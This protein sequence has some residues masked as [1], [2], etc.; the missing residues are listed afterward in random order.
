MARRNELDLLSFVQRNLL[1]PMYTDVDE[2]LREARQALSEYCREVDFFPLASDRHTRGRELLAVKALLRGKAYNELWATS[3]AYRRRIEE[4]FDSTAYDVVHFDTISLMQYADL[5]PEGCTT[6]LDHHNVESH[7]LW[8]RADNETH[9]LRR[10]Y[11]ALEARL[12][13]E[14]ERFWCPVVNLNIVCSDMD[15][16]RLRDVAPGSRVVTVPNGV[17]IGFFDAPAAQPRARRIV[18]VGTLDW[19]P[20]T[21]AVRMIAHDIWPRL[22]ERDPEIECDIIGGR[23][24]AD[25]V[26]LADRDD[27]FHVHGFVDDIHPWIDQALCY[28]CPIK[29]GGGTKLKILDAL[30]MSKAIVAH[31]IACEGIEVTDGLDVIFAETPDQYVDAILRLRDDEPLR[32]GLEH[33]ARRLAVERYSFH[34][35]GDHFQQTLEQTQVSARP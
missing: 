12:V 6:V 25:L 1:A 15:A 31:R 35:I 29:D 21:A 18:F 8:R 30:A 11:F 32:H 14:M 10:G 34:A 7:M 16:D 13:E 23:P 24:P 20:N 27:R 9:P 19:Y 2:G 22:R 17:D 33:N 26:E 4:A 28:V 5:V 3:D